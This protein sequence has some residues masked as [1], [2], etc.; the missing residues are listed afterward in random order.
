VAENYIGLLCVRC[1]RFIEFELPVTFCAPPLCEE[2]ED[3][4]IEADQVEASRTGGS[5]G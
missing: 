1:D 4:D 2:C 5:D 3:E